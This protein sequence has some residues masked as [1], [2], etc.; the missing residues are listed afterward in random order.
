VAHA[1]DWQNPILA[2]DLVIPANAGIQCLEFLLVIPAQ[3]GIQLFLSRS[4][5]QRKL[6]SSSFSLARHSS[7]SW[8]PALSLSLVIPAQVGIQFFLFSFKVEPE[9]P[10]LLRRS[11]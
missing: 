3:A 6:E 9:L 8:N 11:G 10:L 2:P 7:A 5:F 4:S 1:E